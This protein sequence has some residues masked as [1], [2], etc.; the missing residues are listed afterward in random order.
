MV[1]GRFLEVNQKKFKFYSTL[2]YGR[3]GQVPAE[4]AS[5]PGGAVSQVRSQLSPPLSQ[6]A[7]YGMAASVPDRSLVSELAWCFLDSLY[8]TEDAAPLPNGSAA[9]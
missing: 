3:S 1:F 2:L 5:V 6:V 4:P 7:L 9:K 8:V